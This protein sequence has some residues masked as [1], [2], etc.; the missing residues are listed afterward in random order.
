[1][2]GITDGVTGGI[3]GVEGAD[4]VEVPFPAFKILI[5][6]IFDNTTPKE[7]QRLD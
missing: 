2:T 3:T 1:M 5:L 6:D 4:I 7:E